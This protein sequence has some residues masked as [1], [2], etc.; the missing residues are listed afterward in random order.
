MNLYLKNWYALIN[1]YWGLTSAGY[2]F[3]LSEPY[4]PSQAR[5]EM[6]TDIL[7]HINAQ[8]HNVFHCTK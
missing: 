6:Q 7:I 3:S 8:K 5:Q 2:K 4:E 1:N